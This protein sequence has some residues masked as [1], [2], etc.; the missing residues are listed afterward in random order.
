MLEKD[1]DQAREFA[2]F[3]RQLYAIYEVQCRSVYDH[4]AF[5]FEI[6]REDLK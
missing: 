1:S 6:R 4:E 2:L 5:S 3:K